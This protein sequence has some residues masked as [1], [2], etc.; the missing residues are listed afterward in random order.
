MHIRK[1]V[2]YIETSFSGIFIFSLLISHVYMVDKVFIPICCIFHVRAGLTAKIKTMASLKTVRCPKLW[3][4]F[5]KSVAATL[6]K[7][8]HMAQK[9]YQGLVLF[10]NKYSGSKS[11][12]DLK[13]DH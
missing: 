8:L 10:H 4:Y 9:E 6:N 11:Q 5:I 3:L 13:F 1:S 7:A 12:I 2:F